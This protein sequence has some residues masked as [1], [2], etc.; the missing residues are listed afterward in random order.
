MSVPCDTQGASTVSLVIS[1]EKW[2]L[3]GAHE[4]S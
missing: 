1:C 2:S 3:S 4:E